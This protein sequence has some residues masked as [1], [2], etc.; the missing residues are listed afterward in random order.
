MKRIRW[1]NIVWLAAVAMSIVLLVKLPSSLHRLSND[2]D[3][4]HRERDTLV[5]IIVLGL[6]IIIVLGIL[7]IITSTRR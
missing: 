1:D 4:T 3:V 2:F 7:R 5:S 6:I